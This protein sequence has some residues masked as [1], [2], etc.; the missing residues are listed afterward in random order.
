VNDIKVDV[1]SSIG[2]NKLGSF[3]WGYG[4]W[5]GPCGHADEISVFTKRRVSID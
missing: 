2:R 1:I 4:Q 5:K 3:S